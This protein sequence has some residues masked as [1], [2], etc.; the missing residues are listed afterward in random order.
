MTRE[1][2]VIM[3]GIICVF[4]GIGI[5]ILYDKHQQYQWFLS[6]VKRLWGSIPERE[7][8]AEELE[9]ISHYARHHQ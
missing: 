4:A 2:I 8:T 7:Y 1:T 6:K 9:S 5:S 3:V